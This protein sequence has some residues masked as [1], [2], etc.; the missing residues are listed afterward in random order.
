MNNKLHT[1]IEDGNK[2]T[3]QVVVFI[4]ALISLLTILITLIAVS[5][6]LRNASLVDRDSIQQEFIRV[7]E[8]GTSAH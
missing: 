5:S 8:S 6:N 4:T 2:L 1:D 7:K 3:A